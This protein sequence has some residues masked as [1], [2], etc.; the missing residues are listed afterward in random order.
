MTFQIKYGLSD[1]PRSVNVKSTKV[2][3][4]ISLDTYE[5]PQAYHSPLPLTKKKK[6][7][8]DDIISEKQIIPEECVSYYMD[9]VVE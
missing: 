4:H 2:G 9:F 5:L 1:A 3:R 7:D 8:L 6:K